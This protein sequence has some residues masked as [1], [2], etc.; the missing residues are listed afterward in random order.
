[1]PISSNAGTMQIVIAEHAVDRAVEVLAETADAGDRLGVRAKGLAP[2]IAGEHA[3]VVALSAQQR[4]HALH[5]SLAHLHMHVADMENGE[6][7]EARG[8]IR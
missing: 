5:G 1:M 2:V 8:K 6:A 3:D 7:V 4:G